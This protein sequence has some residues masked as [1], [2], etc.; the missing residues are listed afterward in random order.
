[1]KIYEVDREI[2]HATRQSIAN[3]LTQQ[4]T[5]HEKSGTYDQILTGIHLALES[6]D[7]AYIVVAEIEE[8]IVGVAF[9]NIGISLARG[10]HYMWLNELYV[11]EDQRNKG[12]ARKLLLHVIYWAERNGIKSIELETGI[13]NAV[14]KHI[15]HSLG[16][17]EVVSKR[18]GFSF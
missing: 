1:M 17:Y 2:S 4:R 13:N 6:K 3:L 5:S 15:Y 18:Y 12:I 7:T 11:Q 10:G 8:E 9:F 16:F 14:T